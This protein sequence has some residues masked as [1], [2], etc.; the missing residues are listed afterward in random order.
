MP[1]LSYNLWLCE[2]IDKLRHNLVL[3]YLCMNKYY[4]IR[5]SNNM[6]WSATLGHNIMT[7]ALMMLF[8]YF[9]GQ[10]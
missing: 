9:F 2:T 8:L 7:N 10:E 1:I 3:T 4:N 5:N 6:S